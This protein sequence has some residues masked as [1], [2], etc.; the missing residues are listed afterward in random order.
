MDALRAFVAGNA[1]FIAWVLLT[2]TLMLRFD[3][4]YGWNGNG[5][6]TKATT[7]TTAKER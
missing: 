6:C 2:I 7:A 1:A 4:T 3:Y 5:S